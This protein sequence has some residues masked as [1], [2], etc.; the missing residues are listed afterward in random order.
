[1]YICREMSYKSKQTKK[2]L[3][4]LHLFMFGKISRALPRSI[5]CQLFCASVAITSCHGL[6]CQ[7]AKYDKGICSPPFQVGWGRESGKKKK[8]K[9][10]GWDKDSLIGQRR[11]GK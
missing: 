8:V 6:T 7:A 9:L 11:N 5:M 10:V 3:V 4:I 1:M 2:L